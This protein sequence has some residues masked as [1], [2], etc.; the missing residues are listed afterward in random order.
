MS[1]TSTES[2]RRVAAIRADLDRRARR[3]LRT[4]LIQFPLAL[5]LVGGLIFAMAAGGAFSHHGTTY[6][7]L[8]EASTSRA[9]GILGLKIV[10]VLAGLYL[11]GVFGAYAVRRLRA[12]RRAERLFEG[13]S[14]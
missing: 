9:G 14:L 3:T 2:A 6:V 11:G 4:R 7:S 13:E 8:Q 5:V 1:T 12:Q 10:T